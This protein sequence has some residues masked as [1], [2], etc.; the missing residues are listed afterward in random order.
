M[1]CIPSCTLA[2]IFLFSMLYVT[3][4]VD[5]NYVNNTLMNG[6]SEDLKKEYIKRVHERRTIYMTGFFAGLIISLAS[7]FILRQTIPFGSVS[8][9]C[10]LIALT[11]IVSFI[12]YHLTPKMSLFVTLL[13]KPEDRANWEKMYKYMQ[14]NYMMSLIF[15]V[16]FVGLLGYGLC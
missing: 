12:Y 9:G 4:M 14:Y 5:K 1:I 10:F 7:L 2:A 11:Y 8:S 16:L 3:F 13:N 15:G 6:L